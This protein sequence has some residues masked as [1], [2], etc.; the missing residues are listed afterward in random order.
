MRIGKHT[1]LLLVMTLAALFAL[2]ACGAEDEKSGAK[3]AGAQAPATADSGAKP[4]APG[5]ESQNAGSAP[6]VEPQKADG[7]QKK[8]EASPAGADAT[9]EN[10]REAK[11]DM[12]NNASPNSGESAVPVEKDLL[13][14]RFELQSINGAAYNLKEKRPSLEFNEGFQMSGAICN[15][16]MGKASLE[17]GVLRAPHMAATRKLCF[18]EA[19]NRLEIDFFSLMQSGAELE[20]DG[21]R[22]VLRGKS[23]EKDIVLEF[24]ISDWVR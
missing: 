16:F 15:G 8:T 7:E 19:M 17:N 2:C 12:E 3:T 22:L 10:Q 18:E 20:F 4:A 11:P 24:A 14:R 1:L 13:H 6:A 5:A 9:S 21:Q 23:K